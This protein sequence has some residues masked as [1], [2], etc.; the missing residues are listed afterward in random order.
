MEDVLELEERALEEVPEQ[1]R[2]VLLSVPP[3]HGLGAL[4]PQTPNE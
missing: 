3:E 1:L 4:D 2:G